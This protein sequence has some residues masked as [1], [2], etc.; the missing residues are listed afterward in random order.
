MMGMMLAAPLELLIVPMLLELVAAVR[1]LLVVPHVV[2]LPHLPGPVI[3]IAD[4]LCG[5][6]PLTLWTPLKEPSA[7]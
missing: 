1:L 4:I 6:K 2:P 7:C 3:I 5:R